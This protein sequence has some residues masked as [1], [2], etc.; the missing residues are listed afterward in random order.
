VFNPAKLM[1]EVPCLRYLIDN[2]H[3]VSSRIP[4]IFGQCALRRL[5]LATG[6]D[7]LWRSRLTVAPAESKTSRLG[8]GIGNPAPRASRGKRVEP[9]SVTKRGQQ[10]LRKFPSELSRLR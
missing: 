2:E 8:E 3:A 5:L 7:P 10:R 4:D 1:R 6:E 9:G